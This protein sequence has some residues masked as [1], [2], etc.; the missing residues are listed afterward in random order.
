[1]EWNLSIGIVQMLKFNVKWEQK[2]DFYVLILSL[3]LLFL[4]R[5]SGE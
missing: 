1:V 5:A 2:E 3:S 4:M